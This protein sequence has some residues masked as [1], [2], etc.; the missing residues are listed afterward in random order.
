[1][2]HDGPD[3]GLLA[4][5]GQIGP[6]FGEGFGAAHILVDTAGGRDAGEAALGWVDAGLDRAAGGEPFG[7][8]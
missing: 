8:G 4:G 2:S 6:G 5:Q 3:D 1:M 7:G